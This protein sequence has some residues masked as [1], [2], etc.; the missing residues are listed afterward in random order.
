MND[1]IIASVN[2]QI[3]DLIT[4]ENKSILV[5]REVGLLSSIVCNNV[6]Q[7]RQIGRCVPDTINCPL[8]I[9]EIDSEFS[10]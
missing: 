7:C 8:A 2:N 1:A 6:E 4:L 10:R 3:N 5:T 9:G